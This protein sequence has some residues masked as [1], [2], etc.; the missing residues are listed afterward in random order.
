MNAAADTLD[1]NT[2]TLQVNGCAHSAPA[3][4]TCTLLT[5]LREDLRLTAAKRGCN[6]GVCG[7]C[8]VL[9]DGRTARACLTLSH[10]VAEAEVQTLEGLRQDPLMQALQT[11]FAAHGA[12]QCG[13]CTPGMLMSAYVLLRDTP[14]PGEADVRAALSGN[15]CR[16]TGYQSIVAAVIAAG[17]A[18]SQAKEP[19]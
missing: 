15:L 14:R 3:S 9:V 2:V 5:T 1:D 18:H 11:Q 7:A 10:N 13:F 4:L 19:T 12:F 17:Q 16:C 6:Q 8:T